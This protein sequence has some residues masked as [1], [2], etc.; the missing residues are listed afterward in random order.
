MSVAVMMPNNVKD[1]SWRSLRGSLSL[2]I[3]FVCTLER[4]IAYEYVLLFGIA[5]L[6]AL[7]GM[8]ASDSNWMR[9]VTFEKLLIPSGAT[10][11]INPWPRFFLHHCSACDT[12]CEW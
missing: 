4:S 12:L 3:G 10:L 5:A 11:T 1:Q 9:L 7:L 6:S 2:I 8:L